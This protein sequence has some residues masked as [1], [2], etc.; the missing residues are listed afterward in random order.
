MEKAQTSI[1]FDSAC[2]GRGWSIIREKNLR[3]TKTQIE[4]PRPI[5]QPMGEGVGVAGSWGFMFD[6]ERF[7][8]FRK[9]FTNFSGLKLKRL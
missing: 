1:T 6:K 8:C 7:Y 2:P 5:L 9:S 3:A 4:K